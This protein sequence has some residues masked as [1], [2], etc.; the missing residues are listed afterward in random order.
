VIVTAGTI[1]GVEVG[2]SHSEHQLVMKL[3]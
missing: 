2:Y 3:A 1:K